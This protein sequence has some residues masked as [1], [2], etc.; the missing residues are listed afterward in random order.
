MVRA[1][2]PWRVVVQSAGKLVVSGSGIRQM[3]VGRAANVD[4]TGC[5]TPATV[6]VM[7]EPFYQHGLYFTVAIGC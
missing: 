3:L 4:V 5:K 2:S 6:T 7:C 1:G